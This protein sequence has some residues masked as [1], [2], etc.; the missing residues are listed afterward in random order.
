LRV[1]R[2]LR[3]VDI[4]IRGAYFWTSASSSAVDT[5]VP[6]LA[7]I[8]SLFV[9]PAHE[10][11]DKDDVHF[12]VWRFR[13]DAA[14]RKRLAKS[15]RSPIEPIRPSGE[16]TAWLGLRLFR[17]GVEGTSNGSMKGSIFGALSAQL[18]S[19]QPRVFHGFSVQQRFPSIFD[20]RERR[21]LELCRRPRIRAG[22]SD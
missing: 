14:A 2:T 18:T 15:S 20:F 7:R 17:E 21:S 10:C 5:I 13:K 1:H 16:M 3:R 22:G 11:A 4:P 12:L 8:E 9:H 6:P 19:Q